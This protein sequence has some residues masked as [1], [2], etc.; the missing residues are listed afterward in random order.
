MDFNKLL[1]TES[2]S[3][4]YSNISNRYLDYSEED[5]PKPMDTIGNLVDKLCIVNNT[6]IWNQ[7]IL[8]AVRRMT[9]EEFEKKYQNNMAELHSILKRCTDLNAQRA[10]LMDEIDTKL[11]GGISGD[12]DLS[13]LQSKQHKTY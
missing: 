11:I 8:Y 10:R 4:F 2:T 7:D 13:T 9:P 1:N 6:M 5:N 3:E 12:I